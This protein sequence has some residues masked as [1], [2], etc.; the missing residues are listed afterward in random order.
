MTEVMSQSVSGGVKIIL[1]L[2]GVCALLVA[3]L[4][5]HHLDYSWGRFFIFFLLPD[6]SFAGYFAGRTFGA[7]A[8]NTAHSYILPLALGILFYHL[9]I[10]SAA[11]YLLIWIAHI[12]FDRALGYGLKYTSGFGD[13]HLGKIGRWKR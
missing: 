12:G 10:S 1:R 2:E 8:Y 11:P 4:A 9:N 3:C 13:T 7:I 6:I 5:Y